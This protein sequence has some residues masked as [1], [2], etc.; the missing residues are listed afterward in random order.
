VVTQVDIEEM[1]PIDYI[2]LEW[3]GR[4]PQGDAAPLI[5]DLVERGIIRVL[6]VA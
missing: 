5:V 1:G 3:P 6:D 4:Q 2:V